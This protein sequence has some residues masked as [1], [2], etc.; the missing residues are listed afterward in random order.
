MRK[1][2]MVYQDL[3][4]TV[5]PVDQWSSG[6]VVQWSS[7]PL[8]HWWSTVTYDSLLASSTTIE[9]A[10]SKRYWRQGC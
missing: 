10:A 5:G 4:S 3:W 2:M 9:G 8:V 7:G 6:P 1:K